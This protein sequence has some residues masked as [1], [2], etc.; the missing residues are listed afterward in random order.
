MPQAKF[1]ITFSKLGEKYGPLTWLTIPGQNILIVNS[2]E[3]AKELL[4]KRASTYADRPKFTMAGDLLGMSKF[5]SFCTYD[6]WWKKQRS[7]FK[8]ALSG[9]AVKR[10]YSPLLEAGA[11]EYVARC[12]ARPENALY[13]AHRI[14]AEITIKLTY[15]KLQDDR[16]RDYIKINGRISDILTDAA[17]G[18][19]VDLF[20]ALQHLPMWLPGMQ[21]K[22]D[23]AQWKKE[24]QEGV[25]AV[26]ELV[27]GNALSDDPDVQ[28]SFVYKKMQELHEKHEE[29]TDVEQ[30]QE[31]EMA[32][33][34]SGFAIYLGGLETASIFVSYWIL[35]EL[36]STFGLDPVYCRVLNPRYDS[37][38]VGVPHASTQD[39][40]Y[41]GYFIPKGTTVIANA[42]AITRNPKYYSNPS[43]FDPERYLKPSPE[44][45]PREYIFGYGRRI[46]PGKD[47]ASQNTWTLIASTLWAFK[48]VAVE[49]ESVNL[50]DED[51]FTLGIVGWDTV[52]SASGVG[53]D[54]VVLRS[55]PTPFKYRFVPRR[56]GLKDTLRST[57]A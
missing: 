15:G 11:Q 49:D 51:L 12:A 2:L 57:K 36:I 38:P 24:I 17:Q 21:F 5:L 45:D 48:L 19:V 7:H 53:A 26:F 32:L 16:G 35:L 37:V 33:A 13:E 8:H 55:H 50:A 40:I 52:I 18:Y 29:E 54:F 41:D 1:S 25:G 6:D 20:P 10:D 22:R 43:A 27:K 9:G 30:K 23:A 34:Y 46:C 31:D 3:A 44:L 14:A 56:E 42:W 47:L 4:E 39:D 28:S